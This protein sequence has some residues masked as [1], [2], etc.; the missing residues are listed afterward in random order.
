MADFRPVPYRDDLPEEYKEAVY[1][2]A[3]AAVLKTRDD[4][5]E[6]YKEAVYQ[7]AIAAVKASEPK[8]SEPKA[9]EVPSAQQAPVSRNTTTPS[10]DETP[11]AASAS[12]HINPP[13]PTTTG[14]TT[15][16]TTT[17]PKPA[18]TPEIVAKWKD[19]S[20]QGKGVFS[21]A[22]VMTPDNIIAMVAEQEA[23]DAAEAAEERR[24]W[25]AMAKPK[26]ARASRKRRVRE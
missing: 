16:T 9:T 10:E 12:K 23:M 4:L 24:L 17:S 15:G 21:Q 13:T 2:A 14:T 11:C 22:Y 6:E 26:A 19:F 20:A 5:P 7:A 25:Q 8:A 3:M 18:L 1:Q